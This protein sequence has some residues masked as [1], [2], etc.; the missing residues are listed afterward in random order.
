MSELLEKL[1]IDGEALRLAYLFGRPQGRKF[2][3]GALTFPG[4]RVVDLEAF[5][6]R[7]D[8]DSVE[9]LKQRDLM[10]DSIIDFVESLSGL[11]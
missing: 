11:K 1:G 4:I 6:S 3:K 5:A 10:L 8:L 2:L 9:L 7:Q